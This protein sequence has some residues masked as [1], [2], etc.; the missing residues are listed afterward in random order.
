LLYSLKGGITTPSSKM[1]FASVGIDEADLPPTSDM[2]PNI[3]DHPT[4]RPSTKIGMTTSQS[5]AWLMAAPHEYGSDVSRTSPSSTVPSKLS[6]KSGI[7][8]P[9][10]PT[11]ILPSGSPISGNSSCC[12]RMPGESAV[13]NSTSSIS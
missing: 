1:V 6:R 8:S 2:W 11:T 3:D 13:R 7:E 10:C 4:T 9:N 5:L 12:S